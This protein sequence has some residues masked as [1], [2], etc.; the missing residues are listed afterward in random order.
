M[1]LAPGHRLGPYQVVA[2]LGEGGMD[3]VYRVR[4]THVQSCPKP[5]Q[6]Q[7]I[8]TNGVSARW[9]SRDSRRL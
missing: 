6:K 2:K 9:W 7:Q 8:S 1:T 4:D 5:G 3:E